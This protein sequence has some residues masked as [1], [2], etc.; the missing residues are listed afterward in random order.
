MKAIFVLGADSKSSKIN[1][2]KNDI[3]DFQLFVGTE[4]KYCQLDVHSIPYI[5]NS[6][7]KGF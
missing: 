7:I 4:P 1:Y 5:L 3:D 2:L 6:L